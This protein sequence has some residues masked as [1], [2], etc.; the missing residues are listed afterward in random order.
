MLREPRAP[1]FRDPFG[2]EWIL[3]HEIEQLTPEQM[4][5]RFTALFT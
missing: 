1:F 3:G 5:R 4:R 2:H